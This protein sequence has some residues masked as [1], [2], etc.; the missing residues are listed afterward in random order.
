MQ[1]QRAKAKEVK[2]DDV[3]NIDKDSSSH[4]PISLCLLNS[5]WQV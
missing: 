4:Q 1:L 5:T 2:C 3:N